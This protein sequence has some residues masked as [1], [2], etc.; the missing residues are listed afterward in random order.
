[1]GFC[2][3]GDQCSFLH[4][5]PEDATPAWKSSNTPSAVNGAPPPL[6]NKTSAVS[7][8]GSAPMETLPNPSEFTSKR[9][10]E[11]QI[12][13]KADFRLSSLD[14][15]KDQSD[16]PHM[17]A[18]ECEEAAPVRS[19]TFLP[20]R[21]VIQH[22]SLLSTDQSSEELVDG[23]VEREDYLESSPGFDVLVD[24]DRSENLGYEDDPDNLPAVDREGRGL[25]GHIPGYDYEDPVEDGPMYPDTR[26]YDEQER[27]YA[28][29]LFDNEQRFDYFRNFHGHSREEILDPIMP[30]KRK[31]LVTDGTQ[32]KRRSTE[33]ST[34]FSGPKTLSQIKEEKRKATENSNSSGRL[35]HFSSRNASEEFQGPKPLSEILKEKNKLGPV[36]DSN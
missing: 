14:N 36:T 3:K 24:D 21:G 10:V 31:F 27:L 19:D 12:N 35:G 26:M 30:R 32:R 25:N 28:S 33:E 8:A 29:D 23:H 17:S 4:G 5:P 9:S 2:S 34:V 11:K 22:Q 16:S 7:D 20:E 1:M 18:S 6:E 13:L 15:V